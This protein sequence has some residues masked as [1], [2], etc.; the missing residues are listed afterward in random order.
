MSGFSSYY[1]TG[2]S[3]CIFQSQIQ[4]LSSTHFGF[5]TPILQETN[6]EEYYEIPNLRIIF[7]L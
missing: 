4:C 3:S 2:L 7:I 5:S 1:N 6:I